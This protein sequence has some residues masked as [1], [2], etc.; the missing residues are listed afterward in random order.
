LAICATAINSR[1]STH[2]GFWRRSDKES[3][4]LINYGTA[5]KRS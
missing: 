5:G 2:G 4:A 3:S 1:W